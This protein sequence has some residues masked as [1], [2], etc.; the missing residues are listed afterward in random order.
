VPEVFLTS[1]NAGQMVVAKTAAY[2]DKTFKGTVTATENQIDPISRAF[3][4]RAVLPNPEG[5]LKAGMLMTVHLE[6]APEETLAIPESTLI[7]ES[8]RNFVYV[9][10]TSAEQPTALKKEVTIGRRK[11]GTVEVLE[12]VEAGVLVVSHGA[13]KLADGR[14]VNILANQA[15]GRSITDILDSLTQQPNQQKK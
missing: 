11:A 14:P 9:V 12:G 6:K 2:R 10:D 3:G 8:T 13:L 4:V 7:P 1:V 15:D 5:L